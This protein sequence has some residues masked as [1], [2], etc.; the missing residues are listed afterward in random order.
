VRLFEDDVEIFSRSE[1]FDLSVS[2][3]DGGYYN[4]VKGVSAV[5]GRTYRLE[6]DIEGYEKAIA[7][8]IMPDAPIISEVSIDAEHPVFKKNISYIYSLS[9]WLYSYGGSYFTPF[10]LNITDNTSSPDF[11][12][13]QVE[14]YVET[15]DKNHSAV[16]SYGVNIA[17]SNFALIQDNPDVES[18]GFMM[19]ANNFDIYYFDLMMLTDATFADTN[20]RLDLYYLTGQLDS[21]NLLSAV[22]KE[23]LVIKHHTQETFQQYRSMAF[24]HAETGFFSEPIFV[25]SNV[26]N[27]YGGFSV[28]NTV[29]FVLNY[30]VFNQ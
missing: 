30:T 8:A 1:T 17:T 24:Q 22:I 4:E 26:E 5:A 18:L 2:H 7:T 9:S 28:Q 21:D 16:T 29:K 20:I 11:Y 12:S 3:V 25:T 14:H 6:I 15:V 10:S 23:T 19:Y 27:A 13:F